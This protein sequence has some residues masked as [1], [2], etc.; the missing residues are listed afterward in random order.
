M[1]GDRLHVPVRYSTKKCQCVMQDLR[2]LSHAVG[3]HYVQPHIL[4]CRPR[5]S[6]MPIFVGVLM[7]RGERLRAPPSSL[8]LFFSIIFAEGMHRAASQDLAA[9]WAPCARWEQAGGLQVL[10][11]AANCVKLSARHVWLVQE[12]I[13]CRKQDHNCRRNRHQW[14]VIARSSGSSKAKLGFLIRECSKRLV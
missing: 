3:H 12:C 14:Q 6:S 1:V 5:P 11:L 8:A 2:V 13:Q 7:A 4:C 10:N 9:R